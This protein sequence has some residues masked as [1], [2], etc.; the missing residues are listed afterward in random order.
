MVNYTNEMD[1]MFHNRIFILMAFTD[2]LGFHFSVF[3][4]TMLNIQNSL[5]GNIEKDDDV[6]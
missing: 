2:I 1:I 6:E 4:E 3:Y 5:L